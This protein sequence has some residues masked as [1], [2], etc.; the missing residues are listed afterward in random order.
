MKSYRFKFT[1]TIW[2]LLSLVLVLSITGL[3]WNVFNLI[4]FLPLNLSKTIGS[5]IIVFI[6]AV[7]V[8]FVSSVTLY[9]RYKIKNG[10]VYLV[11]G[12][13]F[14]KIKVE[15]IVQF[16]IFK[17]SNKLV[18]Y[19]SDAKYTVIVI[20]PEDYDD[21]I[22]SVRELNPKIIFN[23]EIEGEQNP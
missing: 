7:L 10:C 16:S 19:F 17:K 20:S 3:V 9:S 15:E 8:V 5:A 14:S 21:F 2:V 12:F 4:E 22:A 13:V 11:F 23:K 6:N 1:T 18:A